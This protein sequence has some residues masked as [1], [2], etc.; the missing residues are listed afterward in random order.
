[1]KTVLNFSALVTWFVALTA[2]LTHSSEDRP[3]RQPLP[4]RNR[5]PYLRKTYQIQTHL[6]PLQRDQPF[7]GNYGRQHHNRG[8]FVSHHESPADQQNQQGNSNVRENHP[9]SYPPGER[10]KYQPKY[11]RHGNQHHITIPLP[12]YGYGRISIP[13]SVN[14][15][16]RPGRT[17]V[18][19][20]FM[21][22]GNRNIQTLHST[23]S[24]HS[25]PERP[26]TYRYSNTY[27]F[28]IPISRR[29]Y[30]THLVP[31]GVEAPTDEKIN[32]GSS[33]NLT[34]YPTGR[35]VFR[36]SLRRPFLPGI[37]G[38]SQ[39]ASN[40]NTPATETVRHHPVTGSSS[41]QTSPLS[42]SCIS[43][44]PDQTVVVERGKGCA[45][46]SLPPVRT[47]PGLLQTPGPIQVSLR[48]G[49]KPGSLVTEGDYFMNL[50][51]KKSGA[52]I[53]TCQFWLKV[54]VQ[55]CPNIDIPENGLMKCTNGT[56]WGSVCR[57][58]CVQGYELIGKSS[59]ICEGDQNYV[60]WTNGPPICS[61]KQE[62]PVMTERCPRPVDPQ[63]GIA[64]CEPE[65]ENETYALGTVCRYYCKEGYEILD[66]HIANRV[67]VCQG[68][69]WNSTQKV[70]CK[71]RRCSSIGVPDRGLK[72]CTN[73]NAW[74][75]TCKFQCMPGYEL[76]GRL[77][78][79]CEW[80][81]TDVQWSGDP[82]LC[83]VMVERP[84]CPEPKE[85]QNGMVQCE[86][87]IKDETYAL[88][89]VCWYNCKE[90]YEILDEHIAN[91]VIVCQGSTW[92]STQKVECKKR[93]RQPLERPFC[94]RPENPANGFVHCE[95]E[96]A[97]G[98][99]PPGAS[100]RYYCDVGY[101][102]L[103]EFAD[104]KV[105]HCQGF[106]WNITQDVKC[107]PVQCMKP[108]EPKN[109]FLKCK[110][111]ETRESGHTRGDTIRGSRPN[112]IKGTICEYVCD[113]GYV[114]PTTQL[115]K[116][117]I[118]CQAPNWN[119][120]MDPECTRIVP[121]TYDPEDCQDQTLTV[122]NGFGYVKKPRFK[123]V[124]GTELEVEC[125]VIGQLEP[126]EYENY[127]EATDPELR[128]STRCSYRITIKASKCD[129]PPEINHGFVTCESSELSSLLVGTV[130][131]YV[132]E[133]GYVIPTSQ[134]QYDSLTCLLDLSWNSS[135]VP[136]CRKRVVPEPVVGAC[137]DQSF[138]TEEPQTVT[139]DYPVFVTASGENAEVKCSLLS[140]SNHGTHENTCH[141]TDHELRTHTSCKYKII[142]KEPARTDSSTRR[143]CG[144]LNAPANGQI[145]CQSNN[146][147][148][149][150]RFRCMD[151]FSM[152][153]AFSVVRRGYV[154][155]DPLQGIW[156]FQRIHGID[157]LPDCLGELPTTSLQAPAKFKVGVTNCSDH[158]LLERLMTIIKESLLKFNKDVC[159][160]IQCDDFGFSCSRDGITGREALETTWLVQTEY[161]PEEYEYLDGITNAEALIEEVLLHTKDIV[162]SNTEIKQKIE[163]AGA[164]LWSH[165]FHQDKFSLVCN[166]PG[167]TVDPF[168]NKCL[169][170]PRG[171]YE[172][173]GE[174]SSCPE[175]FYQD[176]TGQS[177]CKPC[178]KGTYSTA[179]T[180]SK[181]E[182][183]E[184]DSWLKIDK[185][186]REQPYRHPILV[187]K[188]ESN[189]CKHGGTC[190]DT[191]GSYF[192]SCRPGFKGQNC[193]IP[194]CPSNYCRNGG[195]CYL[196]VT[197]SFGCLCP[198]DYS[199]NRCDIRTVER[200]PC[201]INNC[202]NGGVCRRTDQSYKCSCPSNFIGDHCE[203]V[204][205]HDPYRQF[206]CLNGGVCGLMTEQWN[207]VCLCAAPFLGRRCEFREVSTPT[208]NHDSAYF[209]IS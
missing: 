29:W 128:V 113:V 71:I 169:E 132:C 25:R 4:Q 120:T 109:G 204:R 148:F 205:C 171:T 73:G 161:I 111:S 182:C 58:I 17:N 97:D 7:S 86:P 54:K 11:V 103:E 34:L 15:Y 184:N 110:E 145:N 129:A 45:V 138:E 95:P 44:P 116:T 68:S 137:Q 130:C 70:E 99:Y 119:S 181:S 85:P 108:M 24:P 150:C 178:P 190:I 59:I 13:F 72:T 10:A 50:Q 51:I 159:H 179:Q 151:G 185:F 12:R 67:V 76:V 74:G 88:G 141:A 144:V 201:L 60:Q 61:D 53:R 49:P 147:V 125:T 9:H 199:G 19:K 14:H 36:M 143:G 175:N 155:C 203:Y 206:Y 192:C 172:D 33:N 62:H 164:D 186:A 82:P 106:T 41:L 87:E 83:L 193:E 174:C 35:S 27:R 167:Y 124:D 102:I 152:G 115:K 93:E 69:T 188:C 81:G 142:I 105:L 52:T 177:K 163:K 3:W 146:G 121:P 79:T 23:A 131:N 64:Y 168:T 149:R 173:K 30:A 207:M 84:R 183:R 191:Q 16:F 198:P 160:S 118:Q 202:Q 6:V 165:S 38:N 156:D 89:T 162:T 157:S 98:L 56:A 166:E 123:A 90:G 189:P 107:L 101:E 104:R 46:V 5:D 37:N 139:V 158:L 77:S 136:E 65:A 180:K 94:S 66:E 197:G 32:V 55:K 42:S 43:C 187:D 22:R 170:C 153:E 117:V 196:M 18:N 135:Q 20:L 28:R 63:D 208:T 75:S 48:F 176:K 31:S 78:V 112:Y 57:F 96:V 100:C 134:L 154:E 39:Y 200:N 21:D 127:C 26:N 114:I 92:N 40:H 133:E 2:C 8:N 80:G 194:Y 195:S 140:V 126:G 122:E 47:C 1:M 209:G 91:K